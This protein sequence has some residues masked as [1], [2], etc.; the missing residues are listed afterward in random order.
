MRGKKA[1]ALR[2]LAQ[3]MTVGLPA[4]NLVVW[5]GRALA[6]EGCTRATYH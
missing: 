5:R 2:K 1:K 6:H 3:A 4:R